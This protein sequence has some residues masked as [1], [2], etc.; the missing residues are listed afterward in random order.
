MKLTVINSENE[1][2]T[3]IPY[4]V[5]PEDRDPAPSEQDQIYEKIVLQTAELAMSYGLEDNGGVLWGTTDQINKVRAEIEKKN[6]ANDAYY[7]Q[8]CKDCE[9]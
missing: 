7:K 2:K 1:K 3:T 9:M 6:K 8:I 5:N 4:L